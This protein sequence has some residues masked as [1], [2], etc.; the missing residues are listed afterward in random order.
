MEFSWML[1]LPTAIIVIVTLPTF[2]CSS[3]KSDLI[4]KSF[5][6]FF[7][8]ISSFSFCTFC[9]D[10]NVYDIISAIAI[11]AYYE[12]NGICYKPPSSSC[13]IGH[14]WE[15]AL[16]WRLGQWQSSNVLHK[17]CAYLALCISCDRLYRWRCRSFSKMGRVELLRLCLLLFHH[18]DHDR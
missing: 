17:T 14:G 12:S 6:L 4:I 8:L 18:I 5:I 1:P 9:G 10:K 13:A 16:R 15:F 3:L 11:T 7:F 2:E